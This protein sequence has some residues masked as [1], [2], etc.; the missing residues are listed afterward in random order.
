LG[1]C[2]NLLGLIADGDGDLDAAEDAFFDA[3]DAREQAHDRDCDAGC[4]VD[5][6]ERCDNLV[7]RAGVLCNLG[8]LYRAMGERGEARKCYAES[9]RELKSLIPKHRKKQDQEVCD[10]FAERWEFIHGMPHYGKMARQFLE[11]ALWG[12]AELKAGR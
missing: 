9:I 3:L 1:A 10:F 2:H 6:T 11:N 12:R 7:Y 4:K 8:H 5:G